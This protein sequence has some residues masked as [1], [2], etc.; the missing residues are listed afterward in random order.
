MAPHDDAGA[1]SVTVYGSLCPT[2]QFCHHASVTFQI[3]V[4]ARGKWYLLAYVEAHL[5]AKPREQ[6]VMRIVC[7][8][9]EVDV[10]S[11][12]LFQLLS[13]VQRRHGSA[14]NCLVLAQTG[15]AQEDFTIVE[16]HFAVFDAHLAYAHLLF[17]VLQQ[18]PVSCISLDVEAI[19]IGGLS[20][21]KTRTSQRCLQ[22][23]SVASVA[24]LYFA[25]VAYVGLHVSH[26]M[27]S[28]IEQR[29]G[30]SC[31]VAVGFHRHG[32]VSRVVGVHLADKHYISQ[33]PVFADGKEFH[34]TLYP[35]ERP[36]IAHVELPIGRVCVN[37]Y[38]H[39]V[40]P[41]FQ[42]LRHIKLVHCVCTVS[43]ANLY[44]VDKG[45]EAMLHS[46]E[47]QNDILAAPF[48][49]IVEQSAIGA[50]HLG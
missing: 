42:T 16:Q 11:L 6:W 46:V 5:V 45:D 28:L 20:I 37:A 21:P 35:S 44:S 43:L 36:R 10:G 14:L 2:V 17:H 47:S 4:A 48:L 41:F 50:D 7:R 23:S 15:T 27:V 38:L 49:S 12:H 25:L 18:P 32:N 33:R 40:A 26:V 22:R 3:Y 24:A 13:A 34:A 30:D 31:N 39:F 1:V 9:D 19:Q 29:S 8:A